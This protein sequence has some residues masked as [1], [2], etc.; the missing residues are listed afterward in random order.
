ML[1]VYLKEMLELTRDKKT[2]IF[3]ILLPTFIMPVILIGF[4]TIVG[5]IGLK[6]KNE[7]LDFAIIGSSNYPQIEQ[8]ML[9]EKDEEG[10]ELNFN[11]VQIEEGADIGKLIE[12][13]VVRF[14]LVIPK[15]TAAEIK[16]G[17][18]AKV[19]FKYNDSFATSGMMFLRVNEALDSLKELELIE[20][21]ASIGLSK[22][23]GLAF[24]KPFELEQETTA[25]DREAL[26]EKFGALLPYILILV[27]LSGA[28]YPALDLGVGEKERGTLETLLLT[29]VFSI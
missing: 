1:R 26:G 13:E 11:L 2:L 4:M 15:N 14:V 29:P 8:Q 5:N 23:E 25:N 3:T 18:T 17:Q 12:D 10:N 24:S 9:R 19:I 21:Y 22:E 27:G 28:M 7:V 6:A 16:A 20:R